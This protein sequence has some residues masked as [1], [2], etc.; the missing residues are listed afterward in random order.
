MNRN[1]E[2]NPPGSPS[3]TSI[4]KLYIY[5][6][7]KNCYN[8]NRSGGNTPPPGPL[9]RLPGY[10]LPILKMISHR[11]KSFPCRKKSIVFPLP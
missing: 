5:V 6:Y 8:R 1:R 10:R 11:K 7:I 2:W 4:L 9:L 3:Y